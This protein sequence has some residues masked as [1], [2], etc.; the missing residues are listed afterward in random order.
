MISN[1][2]IVSMIITIVLSAAGVLVPFF[3]IFIMARKKETGSFSSLGLGVLAYFW[4]QIL[5]PIPVAAV[6]GSFKDLTE[7]QNEYYIMYMLVMQIVLGIFGA[8]ARLWC[9]WLMNKRTPSL[10]RALCSG[11]G[12]AVFG[13]LGIIVTYIPYVRYC[14]ILNGPGGE[15][16]LIEYINKTGGSGISEDSI[17]NMIE[18]MKTVNMSDIIFEGINV[19]LVVI[20]Q[21]ALIVLVYEGFIRNK[22][23]KGM[24]VS[25]GADIVFSF[26]A[27]LFGEL[28][29]DK[30]GIVSKGT[31][32]LIY[33]AFLLICGLLAAWFVY[34][35][36][37]RYKAVLK[38]GP[39]AHYAYFEK[40]DKETE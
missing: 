17:N 16:A 27:L 38:E 36:V 12:F 40:Q 15:N 31:Q 39:Y 7:L 34:G 10:Y 33:N 9:V 3:A 23:W 8:L 11:I 20:I 22:K 5:F 24:W 30:I 18:A 4:S 28:S 37:N 21:M 14:N 13:T 6:I 32:T 19:I 26:L 2:V 29:G 25:A 35:A 1:S